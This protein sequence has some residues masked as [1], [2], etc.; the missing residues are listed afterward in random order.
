MYEDEVKYLESALCQTNGVRFV[1]D[2]GDDVVG[3]PVRVDVVP[4]RDVIL[5]SVP[6]CP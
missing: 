1:N 4:E 2:Q 6:A 3:K 5:L